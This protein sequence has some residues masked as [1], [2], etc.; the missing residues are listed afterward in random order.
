MKPYQTTF[1][2]QIRN[3]K[4]T[5]TLEYKFMLEIALMLTQKLNAQWEEILG[6][7]DDKTNTN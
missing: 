3:L 5:N 6:E 7:K 1:T 4:P 2:E